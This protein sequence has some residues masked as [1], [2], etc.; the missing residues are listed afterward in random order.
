MT[1]DGPRISRPGGLSV[2]PDA[3]AP[4]RRA[5]EPPPGRSAP[6]GMRIPTLRQLAGLLVD[7]VLTLPSNYRRGSYL[8]LLV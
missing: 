4:A 8:D 2:R 3:Q 1:G 5:P 6:R 7:G